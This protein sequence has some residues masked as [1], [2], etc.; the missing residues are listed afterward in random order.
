MTW[1]STHLMTT[2]TP[3]AHAPYIL[4]V[5]STR[6]VMLHVML[7]RDDILQHT[8]LTVTDWSH[9]IEHSSYALQPE[10]H[11]LIQ[12][13]GCLKPTRAPPT[14]LQ[15]LNACVLVGSASPLRLL[16]SS[17][18]KLIFFLCLSAPPISLH[19]TLSLLFNWRTFTFNWCYGFPSTLPQ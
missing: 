8:W 3:F 11:C 4:H 1:L 12:A 16:F 10:C 14:A 9:Y 5:F 19:L 7:T 6:L 15:I 2:V 17:E 13:R 18:D